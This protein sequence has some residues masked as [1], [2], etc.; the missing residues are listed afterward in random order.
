MRD[1]SFCADMIV[2]ATSE[3]KGICYIETKNLDGETNLKHKVAHKDTNPYFYDS[4]YHLDNAKFDVKCESPN[5]MIYQFNG[6]MRINEDMVIPASHE[7][8]LLRG[9]QLRN[10]E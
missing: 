7:Q 2:L 9:C 5:P 10:T 8:F 3:P 1:D 4:D 6:V